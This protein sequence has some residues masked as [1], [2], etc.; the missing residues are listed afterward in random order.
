MDMSWPWLSSARIAG[1]IR[2]VDCGALAKVNVSDRVLSS[3]EQMSNGHAAYR[4]A[5]VA[6]LGRL[7][8]FN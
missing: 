3:A 4:E 7:C 1:S 5:A 2:D 6:L 8:E